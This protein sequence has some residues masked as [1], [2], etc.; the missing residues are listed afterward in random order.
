MEDIESDLLEA[1]MLRTN[2]YS[3][4]LTRLQGKD[5]PEPF[6]RVFLTGANPFVLKTE[7]CFKLQSSSDSTCLPLNPSAVLPHYGFGKENR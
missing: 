6:R 7:S 5:R 4:M 1:Q 2:P 3:R